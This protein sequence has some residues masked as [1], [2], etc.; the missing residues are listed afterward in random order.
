MMINDAKIIG[1]V[2]IVIATVLFITAFCL[3][4]VSNKL[5]NGNLESIPKLSIISEG[6]YDGEEIDKSFRLS[7]ILEEDYNNLNSNRISI[8]IMMETNGKI[9]VNL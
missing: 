4:K 2:I 1:G 9:S 7:T 5:N 8:I 3:K 6:C